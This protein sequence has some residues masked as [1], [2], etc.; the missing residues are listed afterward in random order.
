ML[1]LDNEVIVSGGE[2]DRLLAFF[3]AQKRLNVVSTVGTIGK[4]TIDVADNSVP[5][6]VDVARRLGLMDGLAQVATRYSDRADGRGHG[7]F[8]PSQHHKADIQWQ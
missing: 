1:L 6:N 8:K 2:P 3:D 4:S 7:I 5:E